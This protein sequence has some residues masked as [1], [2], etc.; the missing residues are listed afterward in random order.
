MPQGSA[1]TASTKLL[2]E[3]EEQMVEFS[4][5]RIITSRVPHELLN[6]LDTVAEDEACTRGHMIRQIIAD[7]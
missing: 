7:S 3:E 5:N 1:T 2:R 6:R 4:R